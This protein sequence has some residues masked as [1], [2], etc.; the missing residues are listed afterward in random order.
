MKLHLS[1]TF[2]NNLKAEIYMKSYGC[3]EAFYDHVFKFPR[4]NLKGYEIDVEIEK[5]LKDL[6]VQ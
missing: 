4:F 6:L 3:Y 5:I 2:E 1:I